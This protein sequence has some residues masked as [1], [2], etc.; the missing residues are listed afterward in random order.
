MRHSPTPRHPHSGARQSRFVQYLS[1]AYTLLVAYASLYP[2]PGWQAP[3]DGV[4]GF[5]LSPW[6][7]YYTYA[8]L[9]LNIASY[10]PL[11]FLV[12]LT[13]RPQLSVRASA[14][15]ATV[16]GTLLSFVLEAMQGFMPPRVPSNLDVLC[17]G[18]GALGGGML[19]VTLG[20]RWVLSGYLYA[21]RQQLFLPGPRVDAGFMLVLLWL[22]T[23]LSPEIWL[24]GTGDLRQFLG[25]AANLAYSPLS[26]R[27]IETGVAAVNLAGVCLLVAV[28]ARPQRSLAA[29]LFT[30]ISAALVLKSIAALTLFKTGDAALWLTPGSMLGIPVGTLLY[31]GLSRLPRRAAAAAAVTLLLTGIILV[32]VAPENPY[33]EAAVRTWRYGHFLSFAGLTGLVSALWP[34]AAA[35]YLVTVSVARGRVLAR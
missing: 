18:L 19:A 10:V 17:N 16:A 8:D 35:G 1:V 31:L 24:F 22:F 6:P 7:R 13:L 4:F 12:A 33:I 26:Y 30:L 20:E 34:F 23:Q 27:W 14:F 2:F 21:W 9:L 3:L 25:S 15:A 11:G 29:P 32:N 5:V 28:L